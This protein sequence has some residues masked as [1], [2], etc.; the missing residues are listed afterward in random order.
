[1]TI[2][3]FCGRGVAGDEEEVGSRHGRGTRAAPNPHTWVLGMVTQR[4]VRQRK[5][6]HCTGRSTTPHPTATVP[7]LASA[8]EFM[9]DPRWKD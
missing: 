8:L 5:A 7:L 6:S 3:Q 4:A 1:M 2:P 9:T